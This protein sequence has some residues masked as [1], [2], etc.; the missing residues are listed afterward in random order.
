MLLRYLVLA[1]LLA[2]VPGAATVRADEKKPQTKPKKSAD[3][4]NDD[5]ED[6]SEAEISDKEREL[7]RQRLLSRSKSGPGS[8]MNLI[9]LPVIQSRLNLTDAQRKE[10][11]EHIGDIRR[12]LPL[13]FQ[14]VRDLPPEEQRAKIAELRVKGDKFQAE[15]FR[16]AEA[17]LTPAQKIR[18]HQIALQF[19]GAQALLDP[20]VAAQL[21]LT[22][23]Q[24]IQIL[25]LAI[26]FELKSRTLRSNRSEG[27]NIGQALGKLHE[28][29]ER[30]MLG[31]LT[32]KQRQKY[33]KLK[34]EDL[35]KDPTP[36]DPEPT[37]RKPNPTS[38]QSDDAGKKERR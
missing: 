5:V 20:A 32:D 10:V 35:F 9:A 4:A 28:R 7:L 19:R 27:V 26:S 18:L 16:L 29:Y 22:E 2:A 34:G 24:Q 1:L 31:V 3:I 37:S 23:K 13:M 30:K 33:E 14:G 12:K 8:A 36:I 21:K 6:P 11:N 38:P 15:E 17:A 25:D